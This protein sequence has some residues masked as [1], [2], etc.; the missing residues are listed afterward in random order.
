MEEEVQMPNTNELINKICQDE[1]ER[2]PN[3]SQEE[4]A[5]LTDEEM[6]NK[7]KYANSQ[8]NK[9]KKSLEAQLLEKAQSMTQ[10]EEFR[11]SIANTIN[12]IGMTYLNLK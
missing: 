12:N 2:D 4:M 1:L 5:K 7:E 9:D 6:A 8:T 10:P 11:K 3:L